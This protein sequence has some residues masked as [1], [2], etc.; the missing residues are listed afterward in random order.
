MGMPPKV[1]DFID[2]LKVAGAHVV[3]QDV[4][5]IPELYMPELFWEVAWSHN[6]TYSKILFDD[7]GESIYNSLENIEDF[8][9]NYRLDFINQD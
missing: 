2:N 7:N 1:E 6:G 4:N 8:C 3:V 9:Y 5:I